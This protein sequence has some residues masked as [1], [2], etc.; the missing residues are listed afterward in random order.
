MYLSIK[1]KCWVS[2]AFLGPQS[3]VRR[4]IFKL[5]IFLK[6]LSGP[7]TGSGKSVVCTV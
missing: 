6:G 3:R 1:V 2:F 7:T 4:E 5:S